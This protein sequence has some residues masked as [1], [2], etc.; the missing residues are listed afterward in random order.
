[1]REKRM[2]HH[3]IR[4]TTSTVAAAARQLRLNLTTAE[5]KLWKALQ[6]R[7]LNA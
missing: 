2:Q 6:K 7:Q 4:G 1:M 5:Q 3:R